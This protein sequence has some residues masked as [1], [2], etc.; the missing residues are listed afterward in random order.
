MR[1]LAIVIPTAT[2][3]ARKR[4]PMKLYSVTLDW[5]P[6]NK[7]DGDYC[8]WIWAKDE[9][10]AIRGIAE[11]MVDGDSAG[12]EDLTTAELRGRIDSIVA[13]ARPYAAEDISLRLGPEIERF[14]QGP[15]GKQ[16]PALET[17]IAQ[18]KKLIGLPA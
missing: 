3:A 4:R 14:M 16:S 17:K 5:N 12:D 15:K 8:D 7:E 10:S 6:N 13:G 9:D 18:I 1:N 2:T 11:Q